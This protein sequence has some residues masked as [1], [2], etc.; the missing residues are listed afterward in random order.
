VDDNLAAQEPFATI[1]RNVTENDF[2]RI[3]EVIREQNLAE[4]GPK[5]NQ[6]D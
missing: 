4:F 1:G 2:P 3:V 5:A 6:P